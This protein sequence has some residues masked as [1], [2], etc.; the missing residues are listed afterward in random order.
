MYLQAVWQLGDRLLQ[1]ESHEQEVQL[2][3]ICMFRQQRL[4]DRESWEVAGFPVDLSQ[5]GAAAS[6]ASHIEALSQG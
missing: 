6:A 4:Q 5:R 1:E 2:G 3:H